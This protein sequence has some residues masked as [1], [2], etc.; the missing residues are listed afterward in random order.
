MLIL[1]NGLGAQTTETIT[2]EEMDWLAKGE[3]MC[4]KMKVTL[5]CQRCKSTL[6]GQNDE[7]DPVIKVWCSCRQM[8]YRQAPGN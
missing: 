7:A 5:I 4:R 6:R 2:P 1:P 8:T 3:H